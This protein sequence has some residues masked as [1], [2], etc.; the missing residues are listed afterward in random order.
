VTGE[1][2]ASDGARSSSR[3]EIARLRRRCQAKLDSLGLDL[4]VP[5]TAEA[6]CQGLGVC[7]GRPI[8]LC[9]VDTRT[10]PCG[11]WV[12]TAS[13]HYFFYER[14][15]SS[16]HKEQ[17]VGHE[18]GHA[19]FEHA[20]ADVLDG[21]ELAGLLDLDVQLIRQVLGRAT[22]SRQEEREAEVFGTFVLERA[23]HAPPPARPSARPE[24]A[25]VL[26]RVRSALGSPADIP[27]G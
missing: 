24:D 5:F 3:A 11:L 18:A 25:A 8:M 6:F 20:S 21:D 4:P 26:E 12:A 7:L 19:V 17:I 27:D 23:V 15:T 1:Q 2:T 22:Y 14:A 10:G 13:T 16:L 9:P